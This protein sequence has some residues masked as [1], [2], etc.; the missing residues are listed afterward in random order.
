MSNFDYLHRIDVIITICE[1]EKAKASSENDQQMMIACKISAY[2][3]I[4][5]VIEEYRK[6]LTER[7][8]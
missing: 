3:T 5:H 8:E 4:K 1:E 7:K 2:N 6:D